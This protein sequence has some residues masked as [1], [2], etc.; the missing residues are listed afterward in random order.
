MGASGGGVRRSQPAPA[1]QHVLRDVLDP[2]EQR[3]EPV[4]NMVGKGG[5]QREAWKEAE[6]VS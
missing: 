2:A 3:P 6:N 5:S 1:G 4:G